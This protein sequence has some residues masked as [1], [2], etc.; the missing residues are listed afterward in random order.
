MHSMQTGLLIVG[1]VFAAYVGIRLIATIYDVFL[2]WRDWR[3]GDEH[4]W[5]VRTEE[6]N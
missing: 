5:E 2:R 6:D 4:A 3:R 1:C